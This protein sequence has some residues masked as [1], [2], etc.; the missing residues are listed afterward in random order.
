M[1]SWL[2][3]RMP[4]RTCPFQHALVEAQPR[5]FAVEEA[6]RRVKQSRIK[7][8][9]VRRRQGGRRRGLGLEVYDLAHTHILTGGRRL[10][11]DRKLH[12]RRQDQAAVF[13]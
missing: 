6:L 3:F 5:Q 1:P 8:E 11:H 10:F 9:L 12:A 7:L 13:V 4:S 2:T